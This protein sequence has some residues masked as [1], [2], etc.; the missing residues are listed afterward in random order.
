MLADFA[1]TTGLILIMPKLVEKHL[2][3]FGFSREMRMIVILGGVIWIFFSCCFGITGSDADQY[4]QW[5]KELVSSMIEEGDY[6]NLVNRLLK[7]GNSSYSSYQGIIYYVFG[8]TVIS[9]LAING[10]MAFWGSL[11]L[12][13]AIYSF[14]PVVSSKGIV[15]PLFLIFTPSV[16][17]WSSGNLKEAL[18]YWSV[19]QV[20]AF[21]MPSKSRK[22]LWYRFSL[23]LSGGF[24]GMLLRPHTALIWF[25]TVFI[26]QMTQLKFWKYGICIIILVFL[27][28]A[29]IHEI[30]I[31]INLKSWRATIS[32]AEYLMDGLIKRGKASTFDYG[33]SGPIPVVSGVINAFFRPFIWRT[34]KLIRFF[35]SVEIW[36]ISLGILFL[37][38]KMTKS[39]WKSILR[40][41]IIQIAI[42]VLIPFSFLF[43]YFPNEGLI[44]RQRIQLF[45]ALLVLFATP[46]LQRR[47]LLE[48][49]IA[50]RPEAKYKKSDSRYCRE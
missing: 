22:Q 43:S 1:I 13:W 4:E 24:I 10:F 33:K 9:V 44:A 45:P 14:Y 26:I 27:F 5:G 46:I 37:W 34:E 50:P 32:Q 42:L 31:N 17:F 7:G 8:T 20:L 16:V 35:A 41:P 40:N 19:C 3:Q 39:E 48:E 30:N 36:T 6:T 2:L 12:V 29:H 15:L 23:F 47:M 25:L 11:T 28:N 38:G 18:L 49:G 21:V